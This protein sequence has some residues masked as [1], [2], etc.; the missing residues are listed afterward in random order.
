MDDLVYLNGEMVTRSEARISV[1]DYGFLYGYGLF[2]TMRA[3]GGRVYGG[4][5]HGD[6]VFRLGRHLDR[7]SRTAASLG[8]AVDVGELADA[9]GKSLEVNS[10]ANAR[11]RITVSAGEGSA[12][13]DVSTCMQP[14]V[15]VVAAAYEPLPED[16]YRR[17][18]RAITSSITRN[19]RSPLSSVKS[20]SFLESMMARQEA[21]DAGVDEAVCL[22]E[23]G[24]V[25]EASMSNVF[26]VA[27][28]VLRTP[29]LDSGILPGITREAVLELAA[30]AGLATRE[31][32]IT[33][34]GLSAAHEAFLTNS[35][36]EVM[37][38]TEVDGRPIGSGEPGPVTQ[39]LMA[40]YRELVW[41]EL[42]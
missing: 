1:M 3:Y 39:R 4:R 2:E 24:M 8:L 11:I 14:T 26:M 17:G 27:D 18:F 12:V 36:M 15:L 29:G 41:R 22:N 23:R 37:P 31:D 30:G 32:D 9:V 40:G 6:R 34:E 7:L 35:V 20:T 13:P 33:P 10:L 42:A 21:R 16:A 38:L 28:G 5:S 25:A 19:S